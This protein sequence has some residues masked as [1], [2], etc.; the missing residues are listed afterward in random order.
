MVSDADGG[1]QTLV[2]ASTH[3]P[4]WD[5]KEQTCAP[6][7]LDVEPGVLIDSHR[8]GIALIGIVQWSTRRV[9]WRKVSQGNRNVNLRCEPSPD[10]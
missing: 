3:A 4:L 8:A 6:D 1:D 5:M 9:N 2:P 7:A 10:P